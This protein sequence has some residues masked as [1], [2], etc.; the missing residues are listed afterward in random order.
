MDDATLVSVGQGIADVAHDLARLV[1]GEHAALVQ[2]LGE[3][4]ATDVRHDEEDQAGLLVNG[5]DRDDIGMRQLR[6][7]LRLPE[8]ARLDLASEGELGRQQLDCN[9]AL[10]T[11]VAGTVDNAHASPSDLAVELVVGGERA[12][13]M[14]AKLVIRSS[15]ERVGQAT[16][17]R[18][19]E[20]G[21]GYCSTAERR[22]KGRPPQRQGHYVMMAVRSVKLCRT[23]VRSME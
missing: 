19:G 5:V 23:V 13:Y 15:G 20:A 3:I 16:T 22:R 14:S 10:E 8:K 11:P 18:Q 2:S 17:G 6:R 7:R 9:R 12:L 21:R 1:R 4:V